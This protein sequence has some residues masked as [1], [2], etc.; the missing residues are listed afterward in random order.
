M[1][2]VA[3][4]SRSWQIIKYL[5]ICKHEGENDGYLTNLTISPRC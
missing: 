5:N 3:Y 2:H 4:Y 1:L